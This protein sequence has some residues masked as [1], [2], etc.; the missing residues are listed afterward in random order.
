M[1]CMGTA[2]GTQQQKTATMSRIMTRLGER[3]RLAV[4]RGLPPVPPLV[5][6]AS[7]GA[8]R[9]EMVR[10]ATATTTSTANRIMVQ[11]QPTSSMPYCRSGG[12]TA[13]A[14]DW[15]EEIS[16]TAAPRRRS[17]QRLT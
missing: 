15:P 1:C 12:Q 13:P 3:P 5:L 8:C 9:N 10:P 7:G 11:R 17:N 2:I 16:A 4:L 6:E 14:T